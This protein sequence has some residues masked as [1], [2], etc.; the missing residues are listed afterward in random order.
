MQEHRNSHVRLAYRTPRPSRGV[1]PDVRGILENYS[2]CNSASQLRTSPASSFI[3]ISHADAIRLV[4]AI[5]SAIAEM[6]RNVA[7][8]RERLEAQE[9]ECL[10]EVERAR[11]AAEEQQHAEEERWNV[12]ES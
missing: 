6:E 11:E 12:R 7:A 10:E 8:A 2:S 1:R 9:R 4:P 5:N 3:I